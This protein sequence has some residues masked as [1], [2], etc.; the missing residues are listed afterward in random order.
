MTSK[1]VGN[2]LPLVERLRKMEGMGDY[3]LAALMDGVGP[4]AA[5]QIERMRSLLERQWKADAELFSMR[6]AAKGIAYEDA[7][8]EHDGT[9]KA[10]GDFL[11]HPL[12][13]DPTNR[14]DR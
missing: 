9:H 10:I 1:L 8:K 12:N 11:P 2:D 3:Q 5:D 13:T 4:K 14:H 6:H 7:L